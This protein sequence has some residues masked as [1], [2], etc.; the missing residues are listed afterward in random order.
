MKG[1]LIISGV[2]LALAVS[3]TPATA[4]GVQVRECGRMATPDGAKVWTYSSK[5][6]DCTR[7]RKILH[8]WLFDG[9]KADLRGWRCFSA[10]Q[11][12]QIVTCRR[13]ANRVHM[14]KTGR[15]GATVRVD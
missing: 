7:A 2:V 11:A 12:G 8:T 5:G 9:A 13:G 6:Y 10:T 4:K 14:Q 1:R 3:A 15:K